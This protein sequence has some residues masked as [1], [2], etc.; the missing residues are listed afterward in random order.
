MNI[1][2]WHFCNSIAADLKKAED[3][4]TKR[5]ELDEEVQD[6]FRIGVAGIRPNNQSI[7]HDT[8]IDNMLQLNSSDKEDWISMVRTL[9]KRYV[10]SFEISMSNMRSRFEHWMHSRQTSRRE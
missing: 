3:Q 4:H 10:R 8:D 9:Q 7:S 6:I 2:L 1:A 5:I